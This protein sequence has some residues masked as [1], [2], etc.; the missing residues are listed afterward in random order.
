[1]WLNQPIHSIPAEPCKLRVRAEN[2]KRI[3]GAGNDHE[4]AC[5]A[6]KPERETFHQAEAK[7]DDGGHA[8]KQVLRRKVPVIGDGQGNREPEHEEDTVMVLSAQYL[9]EQID[10]RSQPNSR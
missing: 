7:E 5:S 3:A 8:G 10:Q 6:R 1:M 9:T 2:Q 4:D